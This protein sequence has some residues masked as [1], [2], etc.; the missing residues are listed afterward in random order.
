MM[1]QS[2]KKIL[3]YL[4]I[5]LVLF[6]GQAV[7]KSSKEELLDKKLKELGYM[8]QLDKAGELMGQETKPSQTKVDD[9]WGMTSMMLSMIWGSIGTG[10]FLYGKKQSRFMFLICGIGLCV[11]PI[12]IS[13]DMLSLALGLGMTIAPFKVDF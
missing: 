4:S 6:H 11:F 10:Y 1:P 9:G 12:F 5:L 2:M 3:F 13:N 8:G 7:A